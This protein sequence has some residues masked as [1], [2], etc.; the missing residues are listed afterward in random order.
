MT[1]YL[2]RLIRRA[3]GDAPGMM[4]LKRPG[5]LT[6]E[7]FVEEYAE[8]VVAMP[9]QPA[10]LR[11]P[12]SQPV[13]QTGDLTSSEDG[14]PKIAET[15]LERRLEHNRQFDYRPR[16]SGPDSG[17][18]E[19]E[20]KKQKP[21]L[22][23][24]KQIP[25]HG[26]V[27]INHL[28]GDSARPEFDERSKGM[29]NGNRPNKVKTTFSTHSEIKVTD[30][31]APPDVAQIQPDIAEDPAPPFPP[32]ERAEYESEPPSRTEATSDFKPNIESLMQPV[33][34]LNPGGQ[35]DPGPSRHH[36]RHQ[37]HGTTV[38]IGA[39]VIETVK[40]PTAP[41]R[42][43]VSLRGRRGRQPGAKTA[44]IRDRRRDRKT[45]SKLKYGLGAL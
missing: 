39:V 27:E 15:H 38:E 32:G 8:E 14:M 20:N 34:P 12:S 41:S 29:P 17:R 37:T 3:Q 11:E 36:D 1:S 19:P 7:D 2:M 21:G 13:R 42:T 23:A 30:F 6:A 4:P 22:P 31:T 10:T 44:A 16:D 26:P 25:D 40:A 43:A 9:Q 5:P 18:P 24:Q 35:P 45:V 28:P 33:W